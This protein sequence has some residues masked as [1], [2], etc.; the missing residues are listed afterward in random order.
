M[1][2]KESIGDPAGEEGAGDGDEGHQFQGPASCCRDIGFHVETHLILKVEDSDLV[3]TGANGA[4]ASIGGRIKPNEGMGEYRAE[5]IEKGYGDASGIVNFITDDSR[6]ASL[7]G[8]G[9]GSEV[10]EEGGG[11]SEKRRDTKKPTPFALRNGQSKKG[12]TGQDKRGQKADGNLAELYHKTKDSGEGASFPASKPGR[13]NF[14]HAGCAKGLKVAVHQPDEG[15]GGKGAREG[16]KAEDEVDGDGANGTDEEGGASA[17][18]VGQ[19]PV[20]ELAGAVGER[21]D[22]QHIGD[23]GGGEVELGNHAWGG[24]TKIVAAH[25]VGAVEEADR[26]PVQATA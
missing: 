22:G 15:E 24:K 2:F 21:P 23:L 12:K 1:P 16:G 14:H 10:H 8:G 4:S 20:D 17:D 13:I 11:S 3:G 19:E 26:D 6:E 5:R 9:T 7:L 25:V 18:S